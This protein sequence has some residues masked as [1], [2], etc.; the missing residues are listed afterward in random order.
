MKIS[1]PY[2]QDQVLNNILKVMNFITKD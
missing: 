2:Q 1:L